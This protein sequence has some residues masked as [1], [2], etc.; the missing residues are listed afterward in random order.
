MFEP[1]GASATAKR[2]IQDKFGT[3]IIA[4]DDIAPTALYLLAA[5]STPDEVR[6]TQIEKYGF[7]INLDF[8]TVLSES[9]G[10]RPSTEYHV[11]IDMAKEL[12]MVE[13]NAKGKEVRQ[14]F[15]QRDKQLSKIQS[16]QISIP[17]FTNPAEAAMA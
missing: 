3:A 9:S 6:E 15:I 10:G 17:D 4:V 1:G 11:S 14:Y 7:V 5:P 2:F 8:C 12:S 16:G 13:R